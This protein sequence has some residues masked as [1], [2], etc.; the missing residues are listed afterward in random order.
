[1]NALLSRLSKLVVGY[2]AIQWAGPLISLIF[3][4]IITRALTPQDYGISDYLSTIASMLS[5]LALFALPHALTT[6]FNDRPGD[7]RW[8]HTV[9]GSAVATVAVFGIGVGI[10]LTLGAPAV[11]SFISILEP[12]TFLVV[13]AGLSLPFGVIAS[14][15]TSVAQTAL[16]AR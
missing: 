3:T 15:L 12:Y 1:M 11:T 2:G 7:T 14:M 6:H 16:R 10:L 13:L 8:Q 9:A 5:T 4:P